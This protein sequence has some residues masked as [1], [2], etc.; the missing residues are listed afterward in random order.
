M[1]H[2][3][4]RHIKGS[5]VAVRGVVVWGTIGLVAG[6]GLLVAFGVAWPD[7]VLGCGGLLVIL[8]LAYALERAGLLRPPDQDVSRRPEEPPPTAAGGPPTE[9][10]VP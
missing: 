5:V 7:A 3:H 8:L 4:R 6:C 1:A 10:P 9:P 2:G